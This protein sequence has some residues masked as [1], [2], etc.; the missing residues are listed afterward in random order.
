MCNVFFAVH[1]STSHVWFHLVISSVSRLCSVRTT[2]SADGRSNAIRTNQ[3]RCSTRSML[4]GERKSSSC[5]LLFKLW[6]ILLSAVLRRSASRCGQTRASTRTMPTAT[7]L[8]HWTNDVS[9]E[10]GLQNEYRW[11]LL[12]RQWSYIRCMSVRVEDANLLMTGWSIHTSMIHIRDAMT[13]TT[14][15]TSSPTK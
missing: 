5:S 8:T 7:E 13:M 1:K 10:T 3:S 14:A 11:L 4:F 6:T 2:N 15:K 9:D 12:A